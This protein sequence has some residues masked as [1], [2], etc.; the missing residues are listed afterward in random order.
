MERSNRKRDKKGHFK[1]QQ[2]ASRKSAELAS[3]VSGFLVTCDH[4]KE[5]RAVKECFNL[6]NSTV[7]EVYQE[8]IG[9][10]D[11]GQWINKITGETQKVEEK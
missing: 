4:G 5:K 6:L 7:E 2:A 10:D 8:E 3:G 11:L 1:K 9:D